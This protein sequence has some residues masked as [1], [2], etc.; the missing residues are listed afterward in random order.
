ME[1][2][3]SLLNLLVRL[4]LEDSIFNAILTAMGWVVDS[5][6]NAILTVVGRGIKLAH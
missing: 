6:Y 4:L 5:N 3:R 2:P 1:S